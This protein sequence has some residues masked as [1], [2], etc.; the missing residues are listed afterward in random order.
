MKRVFVSCALAFSL[1]ACGGGGSSGGS[2]GG[3]GG[4][5]TPPTQPS[6]VRAVP[7]QRVVVRDTLTSA[8]TV[9]SMYQYGGSG[10]LALS[11]VS[12]AMASAANRVAAGYART[13][14]VAGTRRALAS[15]VVYSACSNS[16]ESATVPVSSVEVQVYVRTF[17]DAACT[18]LQDDVALDVVATSSTAG[19]V[20]GTSSVYSTTGAQTAYETLQ[21]A[22]TFTGTG[23]IST[24]SLQMTDA[25][26]PTSPQLGSVG[27]SCGVGSNSANCGAGVVAHS[28]ALN[29]DAGATVSLALSG[30]TQSGLVT[31]P[32]NLTLSAYTG[33]LNALSLAAGTFPNWTISGGTLAD[34]ASVAGQL[35]FTTSGMLASGTLTLTDASDH[36]S[37]TMTTSTTGT[38]GVVS[39]TATSTTVATF[40]VDASGNGTVKYSDGTVGQ[41]VN[42]QVVS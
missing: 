20:S 17:Y 21:M 32:V 9:Q 4:G 15:S 22:L 24:V 27:F 13:G 35:A 42:W 14:A 37:V 29:G 30:T 3:G 19:T 38:T 1:A 18:Q 16:S 39:D 12:R 33:G 6:A 26:S 10:S 7:T 11:T 28:Q 8:T 2:V 34:T 23:S 40:T 31:V 36:A 41:I 25:V 5:V